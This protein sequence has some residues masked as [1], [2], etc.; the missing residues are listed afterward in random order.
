VPS[1]GSAR[2]LRL[3]EV[4][5]IPVAG[6]LY[7]PLRRLLGI[8]AF[9]LNAYV[10]RGA[11]DQLIESHDE[12]GVGSGRH[13]EAYFVI[14]GHATFTVDGEEIDAP[15]GTIVFVPDVEAK[16]SAVAVAPNTTAFVVGG[17]ADRPLPTSP[18]EYWFVAEAPYSRGDYAT[19]IEIASEG[20]E[21]WPDHP[22][23]HYQLACY[24]A[25]AGHAEPAL[26]H[27]ERASHADLRVK[28]W[29]ATDDD[30]DSLRSEPRFANIVS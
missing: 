19:A 17:P 24:Q 25:L 12:T 3:D 27:L 4:E 16:R 23:L 9:G 29:A 8:R 6:G 18:F 14:S 28:E 21:Q 1:S 13:E 22:V 10:A 2:A 30:L 15:A 11:G 5:P 7:Q 26:D 20:L